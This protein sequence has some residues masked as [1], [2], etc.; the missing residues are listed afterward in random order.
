MDL[1]CGYTPRGIQAARKNQR[2]VGL[3]L[4]ATVSEVEGLIIPMISDEK[5]LLVGYKAVDATNFASLESALEGLE[6]PICVT[7]EGL[8]M[9]FNDS[10]AA[11]LTILC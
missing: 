4:S 3:D 8:V 1:P 10:E 6:G 11:A 7:T 2:Y 9:Y 5:Q